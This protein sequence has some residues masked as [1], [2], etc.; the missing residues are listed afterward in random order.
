MWI[1]NSL[2]IVPIALLL[3]LALSYFFAPDNDAVANNEGRKDRIILYM[4]AN[5]ENMNPWKS[6]ATTD[7][8]VSNYFFEGML[9]YDRMYEIEPWLAEQVVVRHEVTAVVP[10]GMTPEAFEAKVREK[11]G[12]HVAS[13]K[14]GSMELKV[15]K[16]TQRKLDKDPT[17]PAV[18]KLIENAKGIKVLSIEFAAPPKAGEIVSAVEPQ[19]ESQMKEFL[20]TD[21]GAP[22]MEKQLAALAGMYDE[23][24]AKTKESLKK[25]DF[26]KK[27]K[28][29]VEGLRGVS[30]SHRPVVEM[31]LRKGVYWTDGPYFSAKDKTFV[32]T[33]NGD[34]TAVLV[35]DSAEDA[36]KEIR[37]G[38]KLDSNATVTAATYTETFDGEDGVWWGKGPEFTA[39]DPKLMLEQLKDPLYASP[40]KSNFDSIEEIRTFDDK[41]KIAIVY[42]KLHSPALENLTGGIMPYHRWND[43]N[44]EWEATQRGLGWDELEIEKGKYNPRAHLRS[45]DRDLT[46]KPSYLGSMVL[47]PLNG[48]E[49]PYWQNNLKVKLRKNEFYW[50]RQAEYTFFEYYIFDPNYGAETSEMVFQAG[51]M[52]V[53]SA[54]DY[55]VER[56]E[57]RKDKYYIIKR[58][59]LSYSFLG[60]NQKRGV[61]AD[62]KVRLA[63]SM[64]VDVQAIID[65]VVYGQGERIAGPAYPVLPWFNKEYRIE[66]TWRTGPK[67]GQ[68]EK[69][70]YIPYDIDEARALL[71]EAGYTMQG[72]VLKKAGKPLKLQFINSTGNTTRASV[73]EL[74]RANWGVLGVDVDYKEYEWND[75]IGRMVMPSNFDVVMLGWGGGLGFDKRQL[76]H[77]KFTPPNGLNFCNYSN[78]AADKIMEDVLKVYDVETQVK[79]SHELFSTIAADFPYIFLYSAYSTTIVDKHMVWRKEV[80][81]DADGKPVYEDRPLTDDYIAKSRAS[82]RFFE[83]EMVRRDTIQKFGK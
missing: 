28:T 26:V 23:L 49:V 13:V 45:D 21:L 78:P 12:Q 51:G 56:Y 9:R 68:T 47:E 41:H 33:V 25:E 60:F 74:A 66:H 65:H 39:R 54:K 67:K 24:D 30:V 63:L 3:F 19:F 31:N 83:P 79:M 8:T 42:N 2:V 57:E 1:K 50:G 14:S 58:Q 29:N 76:W 48:K 69:L 59:P 11:Y 27:L 10:E 34:E 20:G 36:I 53:Y 32:V 77:S 62:K 4:S 7:T 15:D 38:L 44:W 35:K 75:F 40:R 37:D 80:G 82:W 22:V 61:V 71:A 5:P 6:T 55:Q 17:G 73:S 72:G 16:G 52:D 43:T 70:Q 18:K 64:A 81:K 46:L